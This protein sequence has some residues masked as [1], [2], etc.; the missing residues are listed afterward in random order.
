MGTPDRGLAAG[1]SFAFPL[2]GV[3]SRGHADV[4][5][6]VPEASGI[7]TFAAG[8]FE[9]GQGVLLAGFEGKGARVPKGPG[10]GD[11]GDPRRAWTGRRGGE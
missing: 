4:P 10:E 6:G 5:D 1:D 9:P 8:L 11:D 3:V 2:Q 7:R